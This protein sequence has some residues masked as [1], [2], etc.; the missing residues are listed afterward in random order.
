MPGDTRAKIV[1]QMPIESETRENVGRLYGAVEG[2]KLVINI[3]IDLWVYTHEM[4]YASSS[5]GDGWWKN[6]FQEILGSRRVL[7]W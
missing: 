7:A 1:G 6:I 4:I 5:F 2:F 3:Q